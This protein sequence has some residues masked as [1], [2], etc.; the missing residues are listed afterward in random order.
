MKSKAQIYATLY[1]LFRWVYLISIVIFPAIGIL[2]LVFQL[3]VWMIVVYLFYILALYLIIHLLH[4]KIYIYLCP[5]CRQEFSISLVKDIT[6][7]N[8]KA[9]AK[10]L[11]CPHCGTKEVME[12]KQKK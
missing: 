1:T 9:G 7:Y 8:A 2:L 6:A 12:A 3:S 4:A 10:V 11:V 5:S